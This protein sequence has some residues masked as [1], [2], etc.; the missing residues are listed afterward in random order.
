MLDNNLKEIINELQEQDVLP[1]T[2]TI[3][4]GPRNQVDKKEGQNKDIFFS[5]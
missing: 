2:G 3:I 4:G 5:Y 1:H